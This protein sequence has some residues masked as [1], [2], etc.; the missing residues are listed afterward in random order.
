ME[1]FDVNRSRTNSTTA[2]SI[3]D[4]EE[5]R[6]SGALSIDEILERRLGHVHARQRLGIERSATPRVFGGG[7]NFFHPENW[8]SIH[9]I[10]R[11]T[12]QA[13]GLYWRARRNAR[14]PRVVHNEIRL[15]A[16]PKAFDGYRILHLSDLHVD[17]DPAITHAVVSRLQGLDYDICVLSGDYRGQTYGDIG[18]TLAGMRQIAA[19]LSQPAYCVLGNHDSICMV[20]GLEDMGFRV[21]I[22]ELAVIRR[23]DHALFL[24][25]IDDAHFF[26][27]DNIE[28][29]AADIPRDGFSLLISHTPEVYRQAAHAGFSLFLC[30]HTHG[31]QICLP[32]GFPL[33]LDATCPRYMGA[34]NWQ[35]HAMHG[36]TSVGAG[37]SI[38]NARLNCDPE[39][40]VHHLRCESSLRAG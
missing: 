22:N 5:D 31:G 6:S 1:A 19:A 24:A 32:G 40:T 27:V 36:Y 30:G 33:T 35:Y 4:V 11:Y 18:P 28:K 7:L 38:V 10:I 14:T 34:G 17:L 3:D 26:R 2:P 39:I 37:S 25:G 8:Y 9:A 12:L 29:A 21:L 15:P 20:P 16:L 13:T 23:G